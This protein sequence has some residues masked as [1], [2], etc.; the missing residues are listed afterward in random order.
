[1]FKTTTHHFIVII[2]KIPEQL[3]MYDEAE[4][5]RKSIVHNNHVTNSVIKRG[6]FIR[7]LNKRG[8]SEKKGQRFTLKVYIVEVV[9]LNSVRVEGKHQKFNMFIYFWFPH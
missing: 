6:D 1:M 8:A 9:G 2:S 5:I 7:L 4:L 3:E